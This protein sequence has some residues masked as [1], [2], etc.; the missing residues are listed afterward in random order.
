MIYYLWLAPPFWEDVQAN[1]WEKTGFSAQLWAPEETL[2]DLDEDDGNGG[3]EVGNDESEDDEDACGRSPRDNKSQGA[4]SVSR[5]ALDICMNDPYPTPNEPRRLPER[6][7][8]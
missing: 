5:P 6:I 7:H 4:L 2:D 3:Y 1:V 8:H